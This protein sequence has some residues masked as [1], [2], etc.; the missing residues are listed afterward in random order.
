MLRCE[1]CEE[2]HEDG[3]SICPVTG[4][5][6]QPER[7]FPPG[8]VLE[9][10]Y[11]LECALGAGGMG[12]VFRAV[13]T[14]LNKPVAI[15]LTLPEL[16]QQR[17]LM[18]RMVREARAASATGHPNI[19]AVTDM[20]WTETGGLFL[21]MEY[22]DG[23]TLRELIAREGRLPLRRAAE[24]VCQVLAGLGAVHQRG[25]VHRDLKP[26]NVMVVADPNGGGELAKV[27]DFGISKV[28]DESNGLELT[29]SGMVMGSPRYMAPE[30]AQG[31][32]DV[33]HRADIYAA[34]GLLYTALVGEPPIGGDT[35]Q[36]LFAQLLQGEIRPP[37]ERVS[38]LPA[39]IDRVVLRAMERAPQDRFATA[40]AFREALL[41]FAQAASGAGAARR[42]FAAAPTFGIGGVASPQ[43]VLAA[44]DGASADALVD[45]DEAQGMREPVQPESPPLVAPALPPPTDR[46]A[47]LGASKG[48]PPDGARASAP[49]PA[50]P[51]VAAALGRARG[52]GRTS[53]ALAEETGSLE[54]DLE[55]ARG[56]GNGRL[57]SALERAAPS[58]PGAARPRRDAEA[59]RADGSASRLL[60]T[61]GLIALLLGLGWWLWAGE[62]PGR[63]VPLPRPRVMVLIETRPESADVYFDGV[64]QVTKPVEL[65][66]SNLVY[67][68]R[69]EA[70]GF[71]SR[72]VEVRADRTQTVRVSL[73]KLVTRP[74]GGTAR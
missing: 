67:T 15:K 41:P 8:T 72:E 42:A 71:A 5:I 63:T 50:A 66:Q 29:R 62:D 70:G 35:L 28:R 59:R 21:V 57:P 10:K 38:G 12:A 1:H 58:R 56:V 13:H 55:A 51:P 25:I 47:S 65:P 17:E 44:I 60:G 73:K 30:Q 11:R 32:A 45:L 46:P 16:A 74:S 53:S 33:D 36:A 64:L 61:V 52:A 24:L 54:L 23:P 2:L 7:L 39:S 37:S 18:T 31:A 14:M 3:Q 27:L 26:E 43:Q 4:K 6:F 19:A 22:L 48:D 9:G 68:V 69:V 40:A 34:G 49:R 20:G